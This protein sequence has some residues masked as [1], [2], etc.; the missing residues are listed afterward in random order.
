MQLLIEIKDNKAEALL[1][2]LRDLPYVKTK[3]ISPAKAKFLSEFKEAIKELN[4][5]KEGKLKARN[6]EDFLNAL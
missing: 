3:T 1:K 4:A 6:A 5:V 2:V